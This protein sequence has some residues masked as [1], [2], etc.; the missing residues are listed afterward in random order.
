MRLV[1]TEEGGVAQY[2][3]DVALQQHLL[4]RLHFDLLGVNLLSSRSALHCRVTAT[5]IPE[6]LPG[7]CNSLVCSVDA[8]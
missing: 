3:D 2:I 7:N 8:A 6:D 4:K 1:Y 5:C